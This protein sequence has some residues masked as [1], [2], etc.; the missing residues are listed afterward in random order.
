[1]LEAP[2]SRFETFRASPPLRAMIQI[3]A[4]PPSLDARNAS[5]CPSGDHR[6]EDDELG[7]P[8][9]ARGVPEFS[10]IQIREKRRFLVRSMVVTVYATVRPSG[11]ICGSPACAN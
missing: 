7:S 11:A 9:S 3:C 8:V 1:M 2:F 6:G 4:F 10:T 5:R